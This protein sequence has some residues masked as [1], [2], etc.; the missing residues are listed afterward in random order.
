MIVQ[1]SGTGDA[2]TAN[3]M[4]R[5]SERHA[6]PDGQKAG[7]K[8]SRTTRFICRDDVVGLETLRTIFGY[9][10]HGVTYLLAVLDRSISGPFVQPLRPC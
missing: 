4:I 5:T 2:E 10:T 1:K 6:A 9:G 3:I 8:Y 7:K